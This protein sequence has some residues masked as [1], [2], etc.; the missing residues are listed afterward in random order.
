MILCLRPD[1]GAPPV[2]VDRRH[3]LQFV[4]E[5]VAGRDAA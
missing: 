2:E 1:V 3:A 5:V 4:A